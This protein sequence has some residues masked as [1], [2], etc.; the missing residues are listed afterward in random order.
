MVGSFYFSLSII[1]PFYE[2]LKLLEQHW[3]ERSRKK[4]VRSE[5]RTEDLL[6]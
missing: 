6:H 4:D 2:Y 5:N 1:A 3:Q